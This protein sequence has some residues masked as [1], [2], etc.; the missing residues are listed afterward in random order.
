MSLHAT[1]AAP[2]FVLPQQRSL[3]ERLQLFLLWAIGAVSSLA[4]I[5][6]SPYEFAVLGALVLFAL[7]GLTVRAALVP[8]ALLLITINIGYTSSAI[9]LF[10]QQG[11]LMWILTS[12]YLATTAVF[13]ALA[14]SDDTEARLN[15]L[16]RGIIIGAIIA[17]VAAIIGYSRVIGSLNDLLLLYG[18]ARGTFKDPNVLGAYLVLPALLC[19]REVIS[20]RFARAARHAVLFAMMAAAV[21]LTFSRA[22][23][24]LTVVAV[25]VML[26]LTFLTTQS[27]SQRLRIVL[28][29]VAGIAAMAVF[30]AALL[31]I[32]AVADLFKERASLSQGYDWGPQGRFGRHAL[33]AIMALDVPLGI[34]PLQFSKYFPEDPHNSF[35][36]AFMA[37]GWLSGVCYPIILISTLGFGLRAVFQ[38]TPWQPITVVVFSAYAGGA[39]ESAIIDIDH[40][41]HMFLLLGVLWGLIV[42]NTRYLAQA[43]TPRTATMDRTTPAL[44]RR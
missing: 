6:P 38:R 20:A 35:L 7:A 19:L 30:V 1:A 8:I 21:L 28:L 41:R 3:L 34:G 42:A 27:S 2:A 4:F 10:D 15:A 22:A 39:F 16:M 26:L 9:G 24:G 32:D 44:A 25:F 18:R 5:E 11:V 23:W 37:G 29:T 33:G 31:S 40:W 13:F 36:N 14:M 17:S 12:W 43:G